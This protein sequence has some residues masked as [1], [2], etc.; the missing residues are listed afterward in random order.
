MGQVFEQ[1]CRE[2]IFL[3]AEN[4]P[5]VLSNIGEW[6]GTDTKTKKEVQIDIVGT[7]AEGKEYLIGSCKYRNY[8]VGTDEL[9][10][11]KNYANVFGNGEN[12]IITSFQNPVLLRD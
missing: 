3:Y 5:I 6:W 2:Y 4:V 12:I 10:L 8:P 1:M 7:P 9:E 11:M